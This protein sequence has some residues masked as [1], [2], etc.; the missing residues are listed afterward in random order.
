M[1]P[2]QKAA[3]PW[4]SHSCWAPCVPG[5]GPGLGA[6]R[7]SGPPHRRCL[8]QKQFNKRPECLSC[9]VLRDP[10]WTPPHLP[11]L[12]ASPQPVHWSPCFPVC[13]SLLRLFLVKD[14]AAPECPCP[15]MPLWT[16]RRGGT[17]LAEQACG[18]ASCRPGV[19]SCCW[20]S[21]TRVPR[22]PESPVPLGS[23]APDQVTAGGSAGILLGPLCVSTA[24]PG[25]GLQLLCPP[26]SPLQPPACRGPRRGS[27]GE[28]EARDQGPPI[29][30][31]RRSF[32][33]GCSSLET[34][35]GT[36]AG[37]RLSP[38]SQEPQGDLVFES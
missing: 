2:P 12:G 30:S 14:R 13:F 4:A 25:S 18:P 1:G 26:P 5:P 3:A 36:K 34:Y 9:L 19:C 15:A 31:G 28:T 21:E 29:L 24:A 11:E 38:L 20:V 37:V 16:W 27:H 10:P 8:P 35:T 7:P 33:C 32:F 17:S 22:H 23:E 6:S